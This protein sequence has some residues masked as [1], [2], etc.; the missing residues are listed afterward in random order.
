[1]TPQAAI[2]ETLLWNGITPPIYGN[3]TTCPKCSHTRAKAD[4]TCLKLY[5]RDNWLEWRCFH[6]N[7][8]AGD[9]MK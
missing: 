2:T 8:Q 3:R 5:P 1:M 6:C 7:W 9:V 4:E